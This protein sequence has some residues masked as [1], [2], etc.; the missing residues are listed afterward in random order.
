MLSEEE[1]AAMRKWARENYIPGTEVNPVFHPEVRKECEQMNLEAIIKREAQIGN[2][3]PF[4]SE[5]QLNDRFILEDEGIGGVLIA[6]A[7]KDDH[8]VG[9]VLLDNGEIETYDLEYLNYL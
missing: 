1:A 6:Y 9:H 7:V 2:Y 3:W 5:K 8:P 4:K